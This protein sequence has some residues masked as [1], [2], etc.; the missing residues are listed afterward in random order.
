MIVSDISQ[1]EET[2]L[3]N[4][5]NHFGSGDHPWASKKSLKG[6][7]NTYAITCLNKML[8]HVED[9][10]MKKRVEDLINKMK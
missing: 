10:G 2:I 7:R 4:A 3:C 8:K 9:D 5:I 6:F 1:E